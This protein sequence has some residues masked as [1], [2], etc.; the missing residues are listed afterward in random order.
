MFSLEF[1]YPGGGYTSRKEMGVRGGVK[2]REGHCIRNRA[3]NR[4]VKAVCK[5]YTTPKAYQM[6]KALIN[7]SKQSHC[8]GRTLRC[9]KQ[10]LNIICLKTLAA[11]RI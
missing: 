5:G 1:G 10:G 11:Y 8:L 4:E 9:Y 6:T 2:N 3:E 7:H